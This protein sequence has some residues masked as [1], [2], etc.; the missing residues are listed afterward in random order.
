MHCLISN[1]VIYD[2]RALSVVRYYTGLKQQ[3]TD[4]S[5]V[6]NLIYAPVTTFLKQTIKNQVLNITPD[7]TG[8]LNLTLCLIVC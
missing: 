3:C 5:M 7:L 8:L 2:H 1:P 4:I 6:D